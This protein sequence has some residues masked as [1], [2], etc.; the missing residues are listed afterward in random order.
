MS[1]LSVQDN[2]QSVQIR[3]PMKLKRRNGRKV[4]ILPE[5][6]TKQPTVP[7]QQCNHSLAATIAR[8]HHWDNLI[9]S[10]RYSSM[11]DLAADLRLDRSFVSRVV[12]L[13]LLAPDIIDAILSGN[14]PSGLTYKELTACK[15]PDLWCEQ[16]KALGFESVV[17]DG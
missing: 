5:G 13:T 9:A 12:R 17:T 8:A 10:G 1:Q 11:L 14:E 6:L 7:D 15:F 3:I 16:R 2:G 4:V